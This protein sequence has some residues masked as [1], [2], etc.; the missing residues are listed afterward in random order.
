M[1]LKV[2]FGPKTHS[3]TGTIGFAVGSGPPRVEIGLKTHVLGVGR[4]IEDLASVEDMAFWWRLVLA[5]TPCW[6][7]SRRLFMGSGFSIG[8]VPGPIE[9]RRGVI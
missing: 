9:V 3:G 7:A 4:V 1:A 6:G 5:P 8:I 2:F